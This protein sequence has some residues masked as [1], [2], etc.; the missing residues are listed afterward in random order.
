MIFINKPHIFSNLKLLKKYEIGKYYIFK[1]K[2]I[3][4]IISDTDRI[5]PEINNRK[6]L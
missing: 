3:S 5:K 6:T 2:I 4:N 1:I